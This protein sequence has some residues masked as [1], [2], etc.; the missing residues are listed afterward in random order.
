MNVGRAGHLRGV[1]E[2]GGELE[3]MLLLC[4]GVVSYRFPQGARGERNFSVLRHPLIDDFN[5]FDQL[6]RVLG[7]Q[8][9][10]NVIAGHLERPQHGLRLVQR[11]AHC[12]L[13]RFLDGPAE[14]VFRGTGGLH[15]LGESDV[16]A[17]FE[18]ARGKSIER[19]IA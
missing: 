14:R 16:P 1:V 5:G 10:R 12:P 8:F 11:V 13:P 15:R 9:V 2:L 18:R 4:D 7:Q 3:E 6:L 19:R 17:D